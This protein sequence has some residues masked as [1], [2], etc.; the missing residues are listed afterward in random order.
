MWLLIHSIDSSIWHT[1]PVIHRRHIGYKQ[2]IIY[3]HVYQS[4]ALH[5]H[6]HAHFSLPSCSMCAI[7]EIYIGPHSSNTRRKQSIKSRNVIRIKPLLANLWKVVK[8]WKINS[9]WWGPFLNLK[10]LFNRNSYHNDDTLIKFCSKC[11]KMVRRLKKFWNHST[12][13]IV[14]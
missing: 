9:L 12:G 14:W 10:Y 6:R 7:Y 8:I 13:W 5:A 3:I 1:D 4:L 11:A 2:L